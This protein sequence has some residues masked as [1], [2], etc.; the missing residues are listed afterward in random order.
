MSERGAEGELRRR[1]EAAKAAASEATPTEPRA[2]ESGHVSPR[3]IKVNDGGYW[4]FMML[5]IFMLFVFYIAG[6]GELQQWINVLIPSP[7][8]APTA[9]GAGQPASG[10]GSSTATPAATSSGASSGNA[11]GT[12]TTGG[13]NSPLTS[14]SPATPTSPSSGA[15]TGNAPI[16]G[17]AGFVKY[18]TGID[19]A[20]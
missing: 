19:V 20:R 13:G 12:T 4:S 7:P 17:V 1:A 2:P 11:P 8:A 14:A 15:S 5:A 18:W 3:A 9:Q 6:K 16:P 10:Y